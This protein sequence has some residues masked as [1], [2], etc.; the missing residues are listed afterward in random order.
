MEGYMITR[1]QQACSFAVSKSHK[2]KALWHDSGSF[3][4]IRGV[5][6]SRTM[7]WHASGPSNCSTPTRQFPQWD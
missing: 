5:E 7:F 3:N 1:A 6:I 4:V 2:K